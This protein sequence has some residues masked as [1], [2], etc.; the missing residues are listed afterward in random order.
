MVE[1]AARVLIAEAD[2]ALRQRIYSR[3]LDFE[4]YADTTLSVPH[5]AELLA[6]TGYAV[7]ILDLEM[8]GVER[9]FEI[10][11]RLEPSNRP[12]VLVT[13]SN[14]PSRGTFDTE[15]VQIVLRKPFIVTHLCELV[16]NCVK[17]AQGK[18]AAASGDEAAAPPATP[19]PPRD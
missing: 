19:T 10:I 17:R 5:A 9:L 2:E 12:L 6:G 1:T 7:A 14:L 18:G 4:V 3:L 13:T 16:L 11:A 8:P 15:V